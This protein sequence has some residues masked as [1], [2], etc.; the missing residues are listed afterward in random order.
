MGVEY[1][2]VV[3]DKVRKRAIVVELG[4]YYNNDAC[5]EDIDLIDSALVE[6]NNRLERSGIVE[7]DD[8]EVQKLTV[9]QLSDLIEIKRKLDEVMYKT[10]IHSPSELIEIM[11]VYGLVR[12]LID[13]WEKDEFEWEIVNEFKLFGY[14]EN[15]EGL[16][17]KLKQEG[18]SVWIWGCQGSEE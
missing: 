10:D 12:G 14:K 15:D 4:R 16:I 5:D 11:K 2:L 18:Y 8:T 6:I 17:G 1:F 3:K 9:G 7:I 13:V